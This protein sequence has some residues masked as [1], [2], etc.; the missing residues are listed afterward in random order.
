MVGHRRGDSNHCKRFLRERIGLILLDGR[1]IEPGNGVGRCRNPSVGDGR[2]AAA[3]AFGVRIDGN[4]SR[5]LHSGGEF[6][7]DLAVVTY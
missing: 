1:K 3:E 4:V 7:I 6:A 5:Y 2:A